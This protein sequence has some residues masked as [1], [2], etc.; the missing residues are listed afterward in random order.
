MVKVDGDVVCSAWMVLHGMV[1]HM[2][3]HG[4]R[5]WY[6]Q[7]HGMPLVHGVGR[8]GS[9]C[10]TLVVTGGHPHHGTVHSCTR[11]HS[12]YVQVHSGPL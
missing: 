8:S 11:V 2:M 1:Q 5:L 7:V 3:Y 12:A 9:W 10:Y 6:V 4:N